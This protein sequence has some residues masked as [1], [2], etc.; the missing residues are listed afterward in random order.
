MGNR[1]YYLLFPY[2]A[3]TRLIAPSYTFVGQATPTK[4]VYYTV[5]RR[6]TLT[7]CI[8]HILKVYEMEKL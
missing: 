2:I 3:S 7:F 1:F 4:W 5:R 6:N 8:T